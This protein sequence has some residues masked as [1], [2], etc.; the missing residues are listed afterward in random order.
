MGELEKGHILSN[1]AYKAEN[2]K[3]RKLYP[4]ISTFIINKNLKISLLKESSQIG[5][6][7]QQ[8]GIE[9]RQKKFKKNTQKSKSENKKGNLAKKSIFAK[10]YVI[11]TLMADKTEFTKRQI[12]YFIP[13]KSNKR[14]TSQKAFYFVLGYSQL[15]TL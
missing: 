5:K 13:I 8:C 1:K 3:I 12:D 10:L 11:A 15:T 14:S 7:I 2:H 6:T 9:E 4:D